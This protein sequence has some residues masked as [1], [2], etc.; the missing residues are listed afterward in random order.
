PERPRTRP[1]SNEAAKSA[2]AGRM[3]CRAD[4][5]QAAAGPDPDHDA[6]SWGVVVRAW[7]IAQLDAQRCR[8]RPARSASWF[9][10]RCYRPVEW[11]AANETAPAGQ[12]LGPSSGVCGVGIRHGITTR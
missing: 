8:L 5:A 6:A 4:K 3:T 11:R 10:H 9:W 2:A 1:R 7:T 12:R